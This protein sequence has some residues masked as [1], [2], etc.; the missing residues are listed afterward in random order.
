MKTFVLYVCVFSLIYFTSAKTLPQRSG[1]KKFP[2]VS[3]KLSATKHDYDECYNKY[4]MTVGEM[5]KTY[6]ILNDIYKVPENEEKVRKH[7]C[8][9]HCVLEKIGAMEGLEVIA[10]KMYS[11][12]R[13]RI[14]ESL[15]GN[16]I[17]MVDN[18]INAI[19]TVTDKCQKA[20]ELQACLLKAYF[21]DL[22]DLIPR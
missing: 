6:Q 12:I 16:V 21:K 10:D 7:G 11:E 4:N 1:R 2:T 17:K 8:V 20:F 9:S 5:F 15:K 22:G 14:Y 19:K 3:R 13:E 18:C